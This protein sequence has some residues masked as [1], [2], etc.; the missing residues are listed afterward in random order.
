MKEVCMSHTIV[1]E[2][3]TKYGFDTVLSDDRVPV[4]RAIL[5]VEAH[6][7]WRIMNCQYYMKKERKDNQKIQPI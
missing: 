4:S 2:C 7:K 3:I 5:G 6:E 1:C